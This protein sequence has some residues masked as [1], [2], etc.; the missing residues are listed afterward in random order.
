MAEQPDTDAADS[1]AGADR[2]ERRDS[3]GP[4]HTASSASCTGRESRSASLYA[5]TEAMPILRH[6]RWIRS[7]ISPR[8]AIRILLNTPCLRFRFDAGDR[9]PVLDRLAGLD[10]KRAERAVDG[11]DDVLAHAEDVDV[12]DE[13]SAADLDPDLDTRPRCEV[14]DRW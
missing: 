13:V 4:M 6:A 11:A 1:R 10:L 8:L 12:A 14:A 7:A 2:Y 5:I 9:L 3:A